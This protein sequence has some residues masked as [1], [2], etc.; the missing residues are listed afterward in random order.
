MRLLYFCSYTIFVNH[1][2]SCRMDKRIKLPLAPRSFFRGIHFLS[3]SIYILPSADLPPHSRPRPSL[4]ALSGLLRVQIQRARNPKWKDFP[5][6][7]TLNLP[8]DQ[9]PGENLRLGE[10]Y[11]CLC[12]WA[13]LDV[14]VGGRVWVFLWAVAFGCFLWPVA[15]G[16]L[17]LCLICASVLLWMC[18]LVCFTLRVY[19]FHE[20]C[21]FTRSSVY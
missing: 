17:R 1:P 4:I 11:V 13:C 9:N 2:K 18:L 10:S 21:S 7:L 6:F 16:C 3:K 20:L 12:V 5:K 15:F 8:P 14:S 19:T